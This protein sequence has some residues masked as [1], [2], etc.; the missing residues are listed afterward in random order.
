MNYY[1]DLQQSRIPLSKGGKVWEETGQA[2]RQVTAQVVY[3]K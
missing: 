3:F 1:P 2:T